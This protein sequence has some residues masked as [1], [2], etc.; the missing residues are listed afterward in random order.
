MLYEF[1]V[2]V[3]L[4]SARM[5][6]LG[7]S[8]DLKNRVS[9][10]LYCACVQLFDAFF[11]PSDISATVI[12][13]RFNN[14]QTRAVCKPNI[15]TNSLTNLFGFLFLIFPGLEG[16]VKTLHFIEHYEQ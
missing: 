2:R 6:D 15:E 4:S 10:G 3:Q 9:L 7:A 12:S 16:T 13:H 14:R 1:S 11:P 5:L 8:F